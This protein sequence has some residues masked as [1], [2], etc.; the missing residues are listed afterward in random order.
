M[1]SSTL[2]A[3]DRH[4]LFDRLTEKEILLRYRDT[5]NL[6]EEIGLEHVRKHVS[7]EAALTDQL[8]ASTSENRNATFSSAYSKLYTELPWLVGGGTHDGGELWRKLLRPGASVYEIGSGAGYLINY[9]AGQGFKCVGADIASERTDGA[10]SSAE[11][12]VWSVTDGVHLTR[13]AEAGSFDYVISDQV[14][15]HLHPDDIATHFEEARKL[16][17]PGGEYI[18]RTPYA[19]L[20]PLDLSQVFGWNEPIFMHLHE[21]GMKEAVSIGKRAGFTDAIAIF[22]V[23][24]FAIARRLR[25]YT[26]YISAVD[27]LLSKKEQ[28]LIKKILSKT[29]KYL[30]IKNNIWISFVN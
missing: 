24:K 17:K 26:A 12:V 19:P 2:S 18:V 3:P 10:R 4:G 6:G 9:L 27:A 15:E 14:V 30:M 21:F 29:H 25:L 13:Y 22:S 8:L 20:G 23:S 5:Y 7:L 11:N 1:T 28:G 16:L